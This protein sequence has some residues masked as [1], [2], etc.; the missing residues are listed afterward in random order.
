MTRNTFLGSSPDVSVFHYVY[1][2]SFKVCKIPLK[3]PPGQ[4][5][6]VMT[7]DN[8]T[9]TDLNKVFPYGGN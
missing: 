7:L 5:L 8:N 4:P 6:Q 3:Q 1:K 9:D 2:E